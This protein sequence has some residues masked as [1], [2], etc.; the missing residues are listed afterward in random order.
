MVIGKPSS[1]YVRTSSSS[2]AILSREYFQTGFLSG[3]DSVM[4]SSSGG[5]W[6]AE[7]E[8]M[9]NNWLVRLRKISM[10]R[11]TCSGTNAMKSATASKRSLPIA[12]LNAA[13]SR[14]S[15]VSVRTPNGTGR[16]D[17]PRLSSVTSIPRSTAKATQAELMMPVPP[18]NSTFTTSDS[19][20]FVHP[21][22]CV[23]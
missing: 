20:H 19:L 7:A 4:G 22:E 16:T 14:T 6:Y 3:L 10:S 17:R 15:A 1:R 9:N 5:V 23:G 12:A 21:V 18:M 8:L 13:G 11:W 2:Q